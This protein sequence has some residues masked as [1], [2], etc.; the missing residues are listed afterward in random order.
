ML[1]INDCGFQALAYY[2]RATNGV[3]FA[4]NLERAG[5]IRGGEAGLDITSLCGVAIHAARP[6]GVAKQRLFTSYSMIR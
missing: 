4:T 3:M 1:F 6:R 5:D 2:E